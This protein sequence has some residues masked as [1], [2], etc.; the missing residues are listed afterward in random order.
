MAFGPPD[1][2]DVLS[3][4]FLPNTRKGKISVLPVL[5]RLTFLRPQIAS[6]FW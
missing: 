5:L 3:S 6:V 2:R 1:E 4:L